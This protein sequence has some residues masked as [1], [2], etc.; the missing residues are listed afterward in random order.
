MEIFKRKLNAET[1]KIWALVI[2]ISFKIVCSTDLLWIERIT[3]YGEYLNISGNLYASSAKVG[4]GTPNPASTLHVVGSATISNG[5]TVSGGTVSLPNGQINNNEISELDWS[6][7]QN[8]PTSCGAGQAIQ[9]VG[10]TLTCIDV[11]PTNGITGSGT[12]NRI[13]KF[14]GTNTIGNSGINDL[15]DAVAITIDSNER[16]GIG[17]TNP[18][19]KLDIGGGS[20]DMWMVLMTF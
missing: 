17:T 19:A 1:V 14:T 18:S 16:V 12:A 15:S 10:D 11:N 13:A 2:L 20:R 6:K 5:L 4:I 9:A 7:L 3:P 8:Y